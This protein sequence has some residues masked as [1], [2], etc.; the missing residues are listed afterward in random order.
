MKTNKIIKSVFAILLLSLTVYG[1]LIEHRNSI[2]IEEELIETSDNGFSQSMGIVLIIENERNGEIIYRM[3]KEDDLSLRSLAGII[4]FIIKG[5]DLEASY[6]YDDETGSSTSLH[7]SQTHY[8]YKDYAEIC[9]GTGTTA[10]TYEDYKLE[11]KRYGDRVEAIGYSVD[12]LQMNA[13]FV[14]TF[15]IDNTY[16]ITEAGLINEVK[17]YSQVGFTI[18]R[19]VFNS[20]NVESGDLLTVKYVIMFN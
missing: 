10:P 6:V 20:I 8:L 16:A 18:F 12:S 4:H 9:I 2:I 19:D 17:S 15:N 7:L 14:T 13:T 3:E 1:G 5:S 11:T